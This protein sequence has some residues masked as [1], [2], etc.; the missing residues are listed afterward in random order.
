MGLFDEIFVE[1]S[2]VLEYK[3]ECFLCH[4]PYSNFQTKDFKSE[5]FNYYLTRSS[6]NKQIELL[7]LGPPSDKQFWRSFS[8]EEKFKKSRLLPGIFS[9]GEWLT[10]AYF[11]CN[12]QKKHRQGFPHQWVCMYSRCRICNP[13]MGLDEF[14]LKFTDG[15]LKELNR[16]S[17]E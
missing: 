16:V 9:E 14:N 3:L 8:E 2:I 4:A 6:D 13:P 11:P 15:F 17:R 7:E 1:E 12:R 5:L 10:A